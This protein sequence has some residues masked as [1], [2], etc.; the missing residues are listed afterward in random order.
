MAAPN[1][2]NVIRRRARCTTRVRAPCQQPRGSGRGRG[3][4]C[5][6]MCARVQARGCRHGTRTQLVHSRSRA[7][8]TEAGPCWMVSMVTVS[9]EC[10]R[11]LS[12]FMSVAPTERFFLPTWR[13]PAQQAACWALVAGRACVSRTARM[14]LARTCGVHPIITCA[15]HRRPRTSSTL[16]ISGTLLTTNALRPLTYTPLSLWGGNDASRDSQFAA[17]VGAQLVCVQ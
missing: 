4:G 8:L 10:E 17:V 9:T 1:H 15:C 6:G 13:R 2:G 7:Q 12:W 5:G 16:R 14:P 3:A 11:L